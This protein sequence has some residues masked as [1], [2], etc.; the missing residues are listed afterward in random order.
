MSNRRGKWG[1][2]GM[3]GGNAVGRTKKEINRL[4]ESARLS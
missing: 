1:K 2:N 4:Q 3:Q